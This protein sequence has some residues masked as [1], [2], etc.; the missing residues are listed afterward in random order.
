[1]DPE[2]PTFTR[3]RRRALA[4]PPAQSGSTSRVTSTL[5]Q[6]PPP[7]HA[8][9][10][11]PEPFMPGLDDFDDV[12]A[13]ITSD[14]PIVQNFV[15]EAL[16]DYMQESL[17]I[18]D[19]D[20]ISEPEA[21]PPI[22]HHNL[23]DTV[24]EHHPE[25][26]SDDDEDSIIVSD[27]EDEN[28]LPIS[29]EPAPVA[30]NIAT[31]SPNEPPLSPASAMPSSAQTGQPGP[32][33]LFL[34]SIVVPP[35]PPPDS[36]V[37]RRQAQR[38]AAQEV[39]TQPDIPNPREVLPAFDDDEGTSF[40]ADAP[41]EPSASDE[42]PSAF[43]IAMALFCESMGIST[44]QWAALHQAMQLATSVNDLRALPSTIKA[45]KD[46]VRRHLPIMSLRG[47]LVDLEEKSLPPQ[48]VIPRSAFYFDI[49]EYAALWLN[50]VTLRRDMHF[51]F[52]ELPDNYSEVYHGKL[53]G[54]SIRTTSG[55]VARF[56]D[57]PG[58]SRGD[59]MFD[60]ILPSDCVFYRR[61]V[62]NAVRGRV[63]GIV[64]DCR[65]GK[66]VLSAR[67]D[68]LVSIDDNEW[69]HV[70]PVVRAFEH[71]L[72]DA[73]KARKTTYNAMVVEAQRNH[74]QKVKEAA[75][76]GTRGP[77]ALQVLPQDET[78]PVHM[79]GF[80]D[81][82]ESDWSQQELL[83][84]EGEEEIIPISDL[85]DHIWVR[86][87][88][89]PP[90]RMFEKSMLPVT[91]GYAVSKILYRDHN[92]NWQ[93]R[94]VIK[95]HRLLA[96]RELIRFG[97]KGA[98]EKFTNL[99]DNRPRLS[100]P[101][102]P[103]LDGFGLY[104]VTYHSLKG[105]YITPV[106]LSLYGRSRTANQFV[107]MLGPFGCTEASMAE[108]LSPE[109]EK[110]GCG[111]EAEILTRDLENKVTGAEKVSIVMPFLHQSG[112]MPQQNASSGHKSHLA[113]RGC[114]SCNVHEQERS[115]IQATNVTDTGRYEQLNEIIRRAAD[116]SVTKKRKEEVYDCYSLNQNPSPWIDTYICLD[117]QRAFPNDVF[118]AELRM[119]KRS[120][121]LIVEFCLSK[122]GVEAYQ[123]AWGTMKMPYGWGR[124]Q[125]PVSHKG[126]MN[127]SENARLA[128]LE[129]F[130]LLKMCEAADAEGMDPTKAYLKAAIANDIR[131]T[132]TFGT[133][134]SS[135]L[136]KPFDQLI[137]MAY[138]YARSNYHTHMG[139]QNK[140]ERE[141][142]LL[143][144]TNS[145][146]QYQ[147]IA[148][149][150]Q[151]D[152]K[153]PNIHLVRHYHQDVENVGTLRNC[154][155][156]QGEAKHKTFKEAASTTNTKTVDLQL[157][158]RTNM[159]QT[160]RF[161]LGGCYEARPEYDDICQRVRSVLR[162]CESLSKRFRIEAIL[163]E[164]NPAADNQDDELML[165]RAIDMSGTVF[166]KARL[167]KSSK[168]I[169]KK[170]MGEIWETDI[171]P[172]YKLSYNPLVIGNP[173][174][175]IS[176]WGAFSA[177]VDST[178]YP[179]QAQDKYHVGIGS[180]VKLNNSIGVEYGL[181]QEILACE[182]SSEHRVFFKIQPLFATNRLR[183]TAAPYPVFTAGDNA[184]VISLKDVDKTL[185]Y[186]V[187][188]A[189]D[190]WWLDTFTGI[191]LA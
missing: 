29:I 32:S 35:P 164:Y 34:H 156:I 83:L 185:P 72:A 66:R 87:L 161:M 120:H 169:K 123:A 21:P 174:Q 152:I 50:D 61:E 13:P 92:R 47:R 95:R 44:T 63:S 28:D 134:L 18:Q 24:F 45:L 183:S 154:V 187:S 54:E 112:D 76:K 126:S 65:N 62:G 155:T 103:F 79:I 100:I 127:F 19:D 51:G 171:L 88:D 8:Q 162:Q 132:T 107:I 136:L 188:K 67:I 133:Q 1:M 147:Q 91:P 165:R 146:L 124:P 135:A 151:E 104:R 184:L 80:T 27:N 82:S 7:Q 5:P 69:A 46:R 116:R 2:G 94:S 48:S 20:E 96:E 43:H 179:G 49:R 85:I 108:A 16:T 9:E 180:F 78:I 143:F 149:V 77:K 117:P 10:S 177:N 172:A 3:G 190:S 58:I 93:C 153:L 160:I 31:A 139:K 59:A 163:E 128:C 125:N 41:R 86:L 141:D 33:R 11:S 101:I 111:F 105:L 138:L 157:L 70:R 142:M 60:A 173:C 74:Q 109:F 110:A 129:P 167:R 25:S 106:N 39:L 166:T 90:A 22:H 81:I 189:D 170:A 38:S 15:R 137:R 182:I 159:T 113:T 23:V 36:R 4:L 150:C 75:R 17:R 56:E 168:A 119:S 42:L 148:E 186:F 176:R 84:V 6:P 64:M 145:R 178:F 122:A 131:K 68:P 191:R 114:R 40:I 57:R 175:R 14:N 30:L 99:Y 121:A 181:V 26:S 115:D 71:S 12:V 97:R 98:L 144:A 158:K 130:I 37:E 102:S 140:K 118:H 52:A 55:K 53:W 73:E 89:Y